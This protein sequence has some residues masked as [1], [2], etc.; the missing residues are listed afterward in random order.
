MVVHSI[1]EKPRTSKD[2]KILRKKRRIEVCCFISLITVALPGTMV[3]QCQKDV[4]LRIML[5]NILQSCNLIG[6]YIEGYF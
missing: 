6:V 4:F 3:A 1:Y 5:A 2:G